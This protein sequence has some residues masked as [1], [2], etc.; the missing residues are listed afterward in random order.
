MKPDVIFMYDKARSP[1][2]HTF[3]WL[4]HAE[5]TDGKP[6][7]SLEDNRVTINRPKAALTMDVLSPEVT[8]RV[9]LAER[10]ESF[11][12]LSGPYD[13]TEADFLAV[14]VP[15]TKNSPADPAKEFTSSLLDPPGWTGAHVEIGNSV[16]QAF[17]RTSGKG[18]ATV[19]GYTTDADRFAVEKARNGS[20]RKVFLRGGAFSGGGIE[21]TSSIPMSGSLD[22]TDSGAELEAD[23]AAA[24]DISLRLTKAPSSAAINGV[25]VR[26]LNYDSSSQMLRLSVPAG[27]VVVTV[28]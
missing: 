3:N 22:L 17:F 15:S 21:L 13:S 10:A 11:M 4:F 23:F 16:V 12:Q 6:S 9:R 19:E 24:A 8:G 26:K 28:N 25:S 18:H 14:L 5:D 20:I 7:V 2:G 1:E 27:H